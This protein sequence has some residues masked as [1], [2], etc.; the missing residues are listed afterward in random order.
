MIIDSSLVVTVPHDTDYRTKKK[1]EA[2][3]IKPVE[4]TGEGQKTEPDSGRERVIMHRK[5]AAR[6]RGDLYGSSG[7]LLKDA[8]DSGSPEYNEVSIDIFV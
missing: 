7:D 5:P 2:E 4:D 3:H 8:S 6:G 1:D